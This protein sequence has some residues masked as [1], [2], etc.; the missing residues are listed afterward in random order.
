MWNQIIAWLKSKNITSHAVVAGIVVL[1]TALTT[2]TQVRDFFIEQFQSHPKIVAFVI[3][4]AGIIFK[5]STSRTSEAVVKD[6]V[7]ISRADPS[8]KA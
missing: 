7:V 6:A 5:Y 2:D 1:A 4:L 8:L 3:S